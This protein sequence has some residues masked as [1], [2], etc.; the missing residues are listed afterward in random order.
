MISVEMFW[1]SCIRSESSIDCCYTSIAEYAFPND[2]ARTSQLLLVA[3]DKTNLSS[4]QREMARLSQQHYISGL[5]HGGRLHFS[6]IKEDGKILDLGTGTGTFFFE[7][8]KKSPDIVLSVY[9]C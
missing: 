5:T 3:E 7:P 9:V 2:E 4:E 6:P 1:S 8:K